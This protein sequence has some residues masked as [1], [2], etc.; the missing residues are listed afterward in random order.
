MKNQNAGKKLALNKR[1]VAHLDM[2]ILSRV[3]AGNQIPPTQ[4]PNL[5]CSDG[6]DTGAGSG[7]TGTGD[8]GG[9]DDTVL[10]CTVT[11]T[12]DTVLPTT[13]ILP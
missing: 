6:A 10:D 1:D 2:T 7:D 5:Y 9:G 3:Q 12:K 4:C 8:T 11:C 13:E